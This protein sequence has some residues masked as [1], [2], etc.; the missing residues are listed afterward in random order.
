MKSNGV[1]QRKPEPKKLKLYHPH[2]VQRAVHDSNARYR[3]SA[4]G[5]QSGK[6]TCALM[7]ML[8]K[9]WMN[10]GHTY[11]FIAPTFSQ[12]LVQ[13][14][15]LIGALWPCRDIILKKNQTELRMKLTNLSQIV[16][17]SGDRPDSLRTETLNGVVIDEVRDQSPELWPLIIRPMLATTKGWA[18][19][20]S[21]PNGFDYFYD[22]FETA[23]ADKTG[24][25]AWFH[26]ASTINP[27]FTM[28][29]LEESRDILS[30]PQFA[31]EI[32]A[33]FRDISSG[34]A[35]FNYGDKN[36]LENCPFTPDG[37]LSPHL[38]IVVAMDFNLSPMAWTLGQCRQRDLYFHDEIWLERSNT[39]EASRELVDRVK[40]HKPGVIL[41]GDATGKAGQRAAAGQSDYDILCRVLDDA[42]IKWVNMTPESNPTIKDRINTVNSLM[43]SAS[44]EIRL[45]HHPRC[46]KLRRDFQRVVVKEGSNFQLDQTRDTTLTHASDGVGYAACVLAPLP[47]AFGVG[48]MRII[49]R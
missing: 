25:W 39:Q 38:P 30:E 46:K 3:I 26:A 4:W 9:A 21:T 1:A 18:S 47:T 6:S 45:W 8:S 37:N 27:M 49:H 28:E 24:K 2:Q 41:I 42:G 11:W 34:R 15:R 35:Y 32:M 19:F 16:F 31:Q 40:G 7:D 12:A 20:I 48:K 5:R 36:I 22:L 14:R 10:S 29:E 17:K 43:F 44:G 23:K 33:E 13:Y